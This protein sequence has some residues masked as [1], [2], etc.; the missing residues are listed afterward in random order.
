MRWSQNRFVIR[1]VSIGCIQCP[2]DLPQNATPPLSSPGATDVPV[3]VA[4]AL[5]SLADWLRRTRS[6]QGEKP[7]STDLT[8]QSPPRRVTPPGPRPSD[9]IWRTL[10]ADQR[11]VLLHALGR[12]LVRRL[13]DAPDAKEVCDERN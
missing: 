6:A 4:S 5:L 10:T 1:G 13:P 3:V 2:K 11:Q 12:L 9:P 7:C 8:D